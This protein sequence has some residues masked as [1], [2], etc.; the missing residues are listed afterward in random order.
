MKPHSPNG[1][2]G[3][4]AYQITQLGTAAARCPKN[5]IL[6]I[7]TNYTL[8][9]LLSVVADSNKGLAQ[10]SVAEFTSAA[11]LEKLT[12]LRQRPSASVTLALGHR[13]FLAVSLNSYMKVLFRVRKAS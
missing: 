4:N 5:V 11:N 13:S 2:E 8:V 6:V 10:L 9:P 12:N 7:Q 1:S 3:T